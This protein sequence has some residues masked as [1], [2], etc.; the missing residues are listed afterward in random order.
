MRNFK[1]TLDSK[2]AKRGSLKKA[3]LISECAGLSIAN[4]A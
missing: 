3:V 2:N 1:E 4:K